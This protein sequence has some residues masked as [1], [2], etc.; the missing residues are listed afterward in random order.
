[1]TYG[2]TTSAKT[3]D[4][5]TRF[6][7]VYA[8]PPRL[9]V[10]DFVTIDAPMVTK[11]AAHCREFVEGSSHIMHT[12][13]ANT[14]LNDH[15]H[16]IERMSNEMTWALRGGYSTRVAF[17]YLVPETAMVH[18]GQMWRFEYRLRPDH[19]EI[20][21]ITSMGLQWSIINDCPD[22][23]ETITDM[24]GAMRGVSLSADER[25]MMLAMTANKDALI[26]EFPDYGRVID[27]LCECIFL[28]TTSVVLEPLQENWHTIADAPDLD[29][30]FDDI[31]ELLI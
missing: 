19:D 14:H 17:P 11:I 24:V 18:Q 22:V 4:A 8:E 10:D 23:N 6:P 27:L 20:V 1:M 21:R 28:F 3:A 15:E 26:N 16:V 12:H 9:F 25:S 5:I 31:L 29:P 7:F 13:I 2:T 30:Y